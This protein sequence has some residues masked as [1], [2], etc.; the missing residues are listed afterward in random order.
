VVGNKAGRETDRERIYFNSIGMGIED[1]IVATRIYKI[2]KE[3]H[4]G[5]NLTLWESPYL[6]YLKRGATGAF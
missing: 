2:A 1:I 5:M 3:R 4:I 6:V